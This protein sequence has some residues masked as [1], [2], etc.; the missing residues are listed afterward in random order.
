MAIKK[1]PTKEEQSNLPKEPS[2]ET[3]VP[4]ESNFEAPI[5]ESFT[6]LRRGGGW[7]VAVIKSQGDKI[8]S[9]EYSEPDMKNVAKER[10]AILFSQKVL[11]KD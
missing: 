4:V 3:K 11:M 9:T 2:K 10:F 5:I 1:R 7:S 8:L 6:M